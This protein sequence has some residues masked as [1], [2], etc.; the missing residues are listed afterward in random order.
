MIPAVLPTY[1]R[2]DIG[3]VRGE[4]PYLWGTDGR[5]YLD[6]GCGVAVTSL[7][8][9][10]PKLV[11]ALK[12]QV[13]KVWHVSNL[14]QIENQERLA[15]RLTAATF[16]DSVFF[17]NSGAEANECA[18]KMARK[19]F[20][21]AGQPERFR[22]ITFEGAFH[23]R[24]LATLAAGGQAKYLEGFGPKAEGFDQVPFGDLEA[25]EKAIGPATCALMIEPIQGESG[26]RVA[27]PDFL[28]G[29]RSLADKYGLLLIYDE[30][31]TGVG[32]T[33]K[34]MAHEWW[35]AKPDI[36]SVA[37]AIGGGFPLG[38]C[39]GTERAAAGM[40]VGTHGSTFGGN[41]LGTAVG[42][43]VLDIVLADGFLEHVVAMGQH[44]KQQLA[45]VA[46][47]HPKVIEEVRGIG[48]HL[49]LKA[50]VP[51]GDL[52]AAMRREG[53]IGIPGGDNVARIMPPLVI[54]R[55]HIAEAIDKLGRACAGLAP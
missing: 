7:G 1:A 43:A 17:C 13:D 31:Q 45:M 52:L 55:T 28:N 4:G 24:T 20:Y 51:V 23:G 39:L 32:R 49:G 47:Q 38:A 9:A 36:M 12:D 6:F 16:A 29:L 3:F 25:T 42:N 48:L 50:K 40:V 27:P 34:F 19:H 2:A 15:K 33:G 22:I 26:I 14:Y 5:R 54:E 44:L 8:H 10:H 11:K 21:A 46:E 53:L 30:I 37:K 18:I 41:P 35:G